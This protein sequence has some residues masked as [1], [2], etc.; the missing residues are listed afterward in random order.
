[1]ETSPKAVNNVLKND[2]ANLTVIELS[3]LDEQE[4]MD[5]VAAT[6]S[7]PIDY[8]LPL[9]VVCLEKS[10]GNPFYL[11]QMLELC[12]R[13]GCIWYSWK[14]SVW[15]YDLDRVFAEFESDSYGQQLNT[16]FITRRLQ[17]LPPAARSIL[18]W[19][20]ILGTSFSFALIQR[21]LTGEFDYSEDGGEQ[22]K[23]ECV[24][25]A[26]LFSPQPVEN[27]VAGLQATL[28]AY[29]LMPGSSEDEF[30]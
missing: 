17:D 20:S 8:V 19:A 26:D 6:L 25:V 30:W 27:V 23:G 14:E 29:I 12:H 15:E 21:L 28:Q 13:K 1:M 2:R 18:A 11:R 4:V 10:S 3:N 9:A 16:S 22:P 24:K 5:Y 7:R